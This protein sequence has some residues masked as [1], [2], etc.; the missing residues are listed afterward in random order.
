MGAEVVRLTAALAQSEERISTLVTA[1]A[2]LRR[3]L[4]QAA[5][6]APGADLNVL[7]LEDKLY[8][9]DRGLAIAYEQIANQSDNARRHERRASQLMARLEECVGEVERR[10]D[11]LTELRRMQA[12]L[13]EQV[14]NQGDARRRL[15][16]HI[17]QLGARLEEYVGEVERREQALVHLRGI[18]VDLEDKLARAEPLAARAQASEAQLAAVLASRLWRWGRRAGGVVAR[19]RGR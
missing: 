8:Q 14:A 9:R 7:E 16:E 3:H 19:L 17:G 4:D 5:G 10:D 11:A 12:D 13:G 18:Q 1:E 15:E 6:G 2:E